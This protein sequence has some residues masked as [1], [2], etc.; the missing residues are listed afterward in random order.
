MRLIITEK[1]SVARMIASVIGA[2]KKTAHW[3]EGGGYYVSWC[4]GHL[5]EPSEPDKYGGG[6]EGK[7]SFNQLPMIPANWKYEVKSDK[8]EQLA[9]LKKLLTSSN[10]TDIIC[11]TDADR[12]GELIFRYVYYLVGCKKPFQRL[13][14]SSLEKK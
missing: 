2:N 7:W 8:K 5:I 3:F 9:I 13:W 10:T 11:A 12:E 1:P 6:W 14:I 4:F